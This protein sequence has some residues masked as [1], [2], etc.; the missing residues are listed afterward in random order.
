MSVVDED[1][2]KLKKQRI[3]L[4]GVDAK[5]FALRGHGQRSILNALS[6]FARLATS[7]SAQ[8]LVQNGWA[9]SFPNYKQGEQTAKA[10]Q[11]G[12]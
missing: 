1:T 11:R 10:A 12:I 6:R 7:T 4:K 8:W 3:R 5:L 2:L 9:V